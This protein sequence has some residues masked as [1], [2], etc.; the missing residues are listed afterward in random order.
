MRKTQKEFIA[1]KWREVCPRCEE[2]NV[3]PQAPAEKTCGTCCLGLASLIP[4]RIKQVDVDH[5]PGGPHR[6]HAEP[7][8]L[9][10]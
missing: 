8:R 6:R 5:Q 10:E 7:Q 9:K 3:K 1:G 2:P 4:K